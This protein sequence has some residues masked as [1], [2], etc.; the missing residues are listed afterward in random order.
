MVLGPGR[1]R[2]AWARCCCSRAMLRRPQRQRRADMVGEAE[3]G[4]GGQAGGGE[5]DGP[6]L[7]RTLEMM[8][9]KNLSARIGPFWPH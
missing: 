5:I 3:A 2:A 1:R 6:G 4:A 9:D 8:Q 7:G